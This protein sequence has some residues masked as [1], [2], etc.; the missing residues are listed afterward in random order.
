GFQLEQIPVALDGV[1]FFIHPSINVT[2]LSLN[3]IQ[4]IFRGSVSNWQEVGGPNIPITPVS[5]NPKLTSTIQML[6]EGLED[7]N[8]SSKAVIVRDYTAAIRRVSKTP[9]AISYASAPSVIGQQTIHLLDLAKA[10]SNQYVP[11]SKN[12]QINAEALRDGTYPFTRRLFVIIRRDGTLDEKAGI[13]YSNFLLSADGQRIISQA[14]F[15]A[16]R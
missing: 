4:D 16:I 7:A 1:A 15:V 3:Q 10:N 6:F 8:L 12:N 9:G 5:L 14:G 2:G 13:A 11:V